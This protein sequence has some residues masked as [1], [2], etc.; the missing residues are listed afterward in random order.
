MAT[1]CASYT[2]YD[3]Y[4]N[5]GGTFRANGAIQHFS[6]SRSHNK[7]TYASVTVSYSELLNANGTIAV[8][9][10]NSRWRLGFRSTRT[11]TIYWTSKGNYNIWSANIPTGQSYTI[12]C[13]SYNNEDSSV[14][15][16]RKIRFGGSGANM[17]F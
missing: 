4:C 9:N 5:V 2:N 6:T 3:L 10:A 12:S 15:G 11:G 1:P 7:S 17:Q 13:Q 16:P 8:A 14:T